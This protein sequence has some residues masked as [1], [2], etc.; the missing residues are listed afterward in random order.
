M[1]TPKFFWYRITFTVKGLKVWV[2]PGMLLGKAGVDEINTKEGR[3]PRRTV[4]FPE[5]RSGRGRPGRGAKQE[6]R[7]MEAPTAW[8]KS[9]P[10]SVGHNDVS[11]GGA[12]GFSLR[13]EAIKDHAQAGR[14]VM[15]QPVRWGDDGDI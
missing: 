10:G 8:R 12:V 13:E 6:T 3:S 4:Q 14:K 15:E 9:R 1:H 7:K 5:D 11:G 2:A